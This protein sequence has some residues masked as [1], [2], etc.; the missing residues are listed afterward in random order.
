MWA[1]NENHDTPLQAAMRKAYLVS[2][3]RRAHFLFKRRNAPCS[4]LQ[5]LNVIPCIFDQPA[6][7]FHAEDI[8]QP[9]TVLI[10][11]ELRSLISSMPWLLPPDH[12][13]LDCAQILDNRDF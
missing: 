9:S 13:I 5:A 1:L 8:I 12:L 3:R 11:S 4:I 7:F 10:C 2:I 6:P